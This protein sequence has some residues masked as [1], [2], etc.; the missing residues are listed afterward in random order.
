MCLNKTEWELHTATKYSVKSKKYECHHNLRQPE[1]KGEMLAHFII[2][3]AL[4]KKELYWSYRQSN[5]TA[6]N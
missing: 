1:C 5:K 6:K 4:D 3:I 2:A